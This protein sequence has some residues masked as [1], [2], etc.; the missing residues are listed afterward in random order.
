MRAVPVASV[1]RTGAAERPVTATA[2]LPLVSCIM[3]TRNR[4]RFVGQA[5]SYFLRQNYPY[6]ELVI[7]DD[8]NDRVADLVPTDDRIRYIGVPQVESVGAKRNIACD[9]SQ[10]ELIAHWDDDDWQSPDRLWRQ[11]AALTATGVDACGPAAM[12]HYAPF[13]GEAWVYQ[14]QPHDPPWVA[15]CSLLYRKDAW[16]VNPFRDAAVGEDTA[17]LAGIAPDAI[18][19]MPDLD[20]CLAVVHGGNIAVKAFADPR[21]TRRPLDDVS[22]LLRADRSFYAALRRGDEAVTTGNAR[23]MSSVTLVAPFAIYESYGALAEYLILGMVREGATVNP[24][25]IS[26][27]AEGYSDE[28]VTL[29]RS[30]RPETGAPVLYDCWPRPELERYLGT[31]DLFI[32]TM[33]ESS[34]LPDGWTE[35]LNQ[36]RAIMVPTPFVADACRASGVTVPIEVIPEGL[37]PEVYRPLRRPDRPGVTTLIVGT[38]SGRKHVREGIAAWQAAFDGNPDARLIIKTRFGRSWTT[39]DDPR[40]RVIDGEERSR[41]IAHWYGEADVL[42]ALGNE[43]FGLPMIEG[44]ATGL[45][46]IALASEGQG[47]LCRE[48]PELLLPVEPERFEVAVEA[49][50]GRAGVR[51]VPPVLA[52]AERLRWVA[53]HRQEAVALGRAASDWVR[54]NRDIWSKA[55][56]V[57]DLMERNLGQRR[58]LRRRRTMW[59]P[60][61]GTPCGV[62]EYAAYLTAPIPGAVRLVADRPR[63]DVVRSLHVQHADGLVA[64]VELAQAI[65]ETR[66]G[67]AAVAVTEHSVFPAAYAWEGEADVLIALTTEGEARLRRRWPSKDVRRLPHGCPT[68]FP[69]RKPRRGRVIG[70][71][72]F[73]G[74]HKGFW[75]LLDAI[76]ELPDT[77]LVIYSHSSSPDLEASWEA[78][79]RGLRVRRVAEFLPIEDVA[80]RLAAEADV[81]VYWYDEVA[82]AS[83]SGA[84]RVGMAT[85]VPVLTSA[86]GWFDGLDGVVH[87]PD[88][89]VDGIQTLL[90]D[91]KLRERL[92]DAA[93][94]HCHDHSWERTAQR[95]L[96]LW[97]SLEAA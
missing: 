20:L 85:G 2:G 28:L 14:P 64:D 55:P 97:E 13:R 26:F 90:D 47:D 45:P 11:V 72:G 17:F 94:A 19:M 56:A 69:P 76:R 33:W 50:Y 32:Y 6:R 81:L 51:G 79:A 92:V 40:I 1:T 36:A 53:T 96:A 31:S 35:R 88:D 80:R 27:D 52:V 59:V 7:V 70:A 16:K 25:P 95:H 4:R 46:V 58:S 87:Q 78:A 24:V 38:P 41:G 57:L 91:T 49:P 66:Q 82:H 9:A 15:G 22:R 93:R 43:G 89:L 71:F 73:L 10:G 29:V 44:M 30:S 68:W 3:P 62:A 54:T 60:G 75:H 8:G 77:T 84:V 86:T 12:L 37:D 67:G 39:P 63:P 65:D 83:A 74:R 23:L 48:V 21:W 34:R 42:V 5:I 18:G 61:N